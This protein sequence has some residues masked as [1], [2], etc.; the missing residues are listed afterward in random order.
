MLNLAPMADSPANS[1]RLTDRLSAVRAFAFDID[2]VLSLV[3]TPMDAAG[4]PMRTANIQDG[5]VLQLAVKLG[6]PIAIIT[7]G[8]NEAVVGR[9][10]GLGIADVFLGCASKL[11]TYQSWRDRHG[12]A[13]E[14]VLYMGDDMP[15]LPILRCVGLPT[16][17]ADAAVDVKREAAYISPYEGGRGCVRDVVEQVLRCHG[18]W[19][20]DMTW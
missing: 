18:Q 6:Y 7:G 8:T 3:C 19:G 4:V 5:Y 15:D 1:S 16:C 17:P 11:G 20:H 14:Q 2:G 12:L 9:Y 10:R 13:D